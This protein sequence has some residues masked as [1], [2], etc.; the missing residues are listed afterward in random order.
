MAEKVFI[1]VTYE[2][3]LRKETAAKYATNTSETAD[4]RRNIWPGSPGGRKE[5][6]KPRETIVMSPLDT[7]KKKPMDLRRSRF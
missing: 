5:S 2:G 7:T 1:M 4:L 3:R 6:P